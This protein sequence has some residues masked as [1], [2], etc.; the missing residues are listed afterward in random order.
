MVIDFQKI[1]KGKICSYIRYNSGAVLTVCLFV[2]S[3]REA[4]IAIEGLKDRGLPIQALNNYT[5]VAN[6]RGM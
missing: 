6:P 3:F 1:L 4:I 2:A 5:I